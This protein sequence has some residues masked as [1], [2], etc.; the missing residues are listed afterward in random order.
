MKLKGGKYLNAI[1]KQSMSREMFPH[2]HNVGCK[3]SDRGASASQR[4]S[5][6][7]GKEGTDREQ[8]I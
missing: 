1:I 5:P 7:E 2:M 3:Y 6:T 8:N 4:N